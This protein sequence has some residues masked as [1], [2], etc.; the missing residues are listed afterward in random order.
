MSGIIPAG[1]IDVADAPEI[2]SV[3]LIRQIIENIEAQISFVDLE[4]YTAQQ[5]DTG[6]V[7]TFCP[8]FLHLNYFSL[9]KYLDR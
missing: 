4:V 2:S 3:D 5:R 9:L 1:K 6:L 8:N 7:R